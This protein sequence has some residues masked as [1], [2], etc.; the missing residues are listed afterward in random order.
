MSDKYLIMAIFVGFIA[1]SLTRFLPFI[2]FD[3]KK[4]TPKILFIFEKYMPFMIM[5]ILVFYAIRDTEFLQFPY[6]ISEILGILC[7]VFLHVKFKNTLFSIIGATFFYMIL[8][9]VVVSC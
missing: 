7:A 3:K 9:R 8:I 6:G 4:D 1:T 5:V 2:L